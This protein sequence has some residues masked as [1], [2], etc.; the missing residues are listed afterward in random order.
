[1]KKRLLGTSD[2][3]VSEICLG[4]MTWGT[5]NTEAE[6]HA[7]ID[8]AL[9]RGVNFIDTAEMY[10][11]TPL[12][13][14][15]CGRTEEIIGT[16]VKKRG[17]ADGVILATKVV[18]S[19]FGFIRDGGPITPEIIETALDGSLKRLNVETID[20]YQL[21]WPNRGHFHFR[22]QWEYDPSGQERQAT[23]DD[24]KRTLEALSKEV[25]RGRIRHIGVSNDTSWGIMK[26]LEIAEAEGFP[27][28]ASAQN[29]YSLMYRHYDL[30]LAELGHHE[31]VGLLA[32]SSLAAGL[33]TGKYS[34]DVVVPGSRRDVSSPEL[35]GRVNPVSLEAADAYAALARDHGIDPAT[36]A[37]AFCLTRPFMASVIIGATS[38][39]QLDV[40]LDAAETELSAE[41]M[42]GIG[43][44][45][46][47]YPIPY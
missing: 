24:L 31:R 8:R 28:V 22:R 15:T 19:N 2:L 5:Q 29:E 6:G 45:H 44:L 3:E 13:A 25:E 11:T 38:L 23:V 17:N 33:L 18:G 27:R 12:S 14:E 47:R 40:C 39:E 1:M 34:G 9:E 36:M 35:G 21:H 4:S 46:R 20:L 32:Y 41:V 42:E 30:D 10:P 7:Q 43:A 26:M 37:L 16:W